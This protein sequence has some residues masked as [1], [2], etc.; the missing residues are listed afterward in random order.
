[1][2]QRRRLSSSLVEFC[3]RAGNFLKR[4]IPFQVST[5]ELRSSNLCRRTVVTLLLAASAHFVFWAHEREVA[6]SIFCQGA[7]SIGIARGWVFGK[8]LILPLPR[9]VALF[10]TVVRRRCPFFK[11]FAFLSGSLHRNPDYSLVVCWMLQRRRSEAPNIRESLADVSE[12][13]VSDTRRVDKYEKLV[14]N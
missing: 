2:I 3:N 13:T 8:F 10:V 4:G 11:D 7:L 12:K 14:R 5:R 6:K 1:M 9:N